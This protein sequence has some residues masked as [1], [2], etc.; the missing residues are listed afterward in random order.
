[1]SVLLEAPHFSP[2]AIYHLL[3]WEIWHDQ[4]ISTEQLFQIMIPIEKASIPWKCVL[5][6][7]A[8]SEG[9]LEWTAMTLTPIAI[10]GSQLLGFLHPHEKYLHEIMYN[11]IPGP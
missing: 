1:M 8:H 2:M 3:S 10:M 4:Q 11:N 9:I 6:G 7:A 5:Y